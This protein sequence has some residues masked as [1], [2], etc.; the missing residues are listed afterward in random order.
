MDGH[1][2]TKIRHFLRYGATHALASS[3]HGAH[4]YVS[5]DYS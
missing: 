5:I 1:V 2:I 4:G 3:A